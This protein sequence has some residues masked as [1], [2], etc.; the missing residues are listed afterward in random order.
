[1]LAH[2]PFVP[3]GVL[4]FF[5]S[6]SLLEKCVLRWKVTKLMAKLRAFKTVVVEP[7]GAGFVVV[8]VVAVSHC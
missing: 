2:L 1:V 4:C 3:G 6:Y 5:P 8:V 7:R